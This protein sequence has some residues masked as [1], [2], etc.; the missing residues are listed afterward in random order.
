MIG[1]NNPFNIRYN[2]R[3]Q[4]LGQIKPCR[5]FCSFSSMAFGIRAAIML[6]MRS[7]RKKN[8]VTVSE[9]INRYAPSTE[10]NTQ[11]YIDYVCHRMAV[12]PFDVMYKKSDYCDLLAAMSE[13]EGNPVPSYKIKQVMSDFDISLIRKL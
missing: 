2:A 3:N 12:L 1:E 8:L 7:Y 5:G 4:W 13:F 9:I 6:I 11:A 10:N